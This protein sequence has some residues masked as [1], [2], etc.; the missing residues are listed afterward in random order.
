MGL[1]EAGQSAFP[2]LAHQLS[3]QRFSGLAQ[4][5]QSQDKSDA[6]FPP[7][8]EI[9]RAGSL[10]S[11]RIS[12]DSISSSTVSVG[13]DARGPLL[14]VSGF[15]THK[16]R[17]LSLTARDAALFTAS[18]VGRPCNLVR[19]SPTTRRCIVLFLQRYGQALRKK[20]VRY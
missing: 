4:D 10:A 18:Q 17:R 19:A 8:K 20:T 1:E 2:K 13:A 15:S 6:V 11:S 12:L 3:E 7:G 9:S 16:P 14:T 5:S